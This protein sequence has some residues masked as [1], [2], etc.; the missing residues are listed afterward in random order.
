MV[1]GN[2]N[3]LLLALL[4][5]TWAADRAGR[6]GWAGTALGVAAALKLFPAFLAVYFLARREWKVLK[7]AA[8]TFAALTLLTAAILGTEAYRTYLGEV[9]PRTAERYRTAWF[10][11]SLAGLWAKLFDPQAGDRG[12]HVIPLLASRFLA[13]VAFAASAILVAAVVA[14]RAAR[15]RSRSAADLAFGLAL[16]GMLLVSPI[17]WEHYLLLPLPLAVLW[18][19]LPPSEGVRW[20]YAAAVAL[21]WLPPVGVMEHAMT[22]LGEE[23]KAGVGWSAGPVQALTALSVHT[24][25]LL[26]LFALGAAVS[27]SADLAGAARNPVAKRESRVV[28]VPA[29]AGSGLPGPPEGGTPT[30][31]VGVP[32]SGGPA[33]ERPAEAGTPTAPR[34]AAEDG[35]APMPLQFCPE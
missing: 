9:L 22:L 18:Q 25:A 21:L 6:P 27:R 17:T 4:T 5:G 14:R 30:A 29:L 15:A 34:Q 26:M 1:H 13:H 31:A 24:W 35:C 3:L 10:N 20:T 12:M 33:L 2:L 32:P 23:P 19:R 28:G 11:L 8:A 7:V 16:L